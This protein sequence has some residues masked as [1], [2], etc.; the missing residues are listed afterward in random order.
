MLVV[1]ATCP[2]EMA[3]LR[4]AHPELSFL[5]P[6]IGAQG[7]DLEATLAGGLNADGAGLL[8][9]SSRAIMYAGGGRPEPIRAAALQLHEAINARRS[10]RR[11][12]AAVA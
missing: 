8:I 12:P 1:G 10:I 3:E 7:G 11:A 5:V 6:G 2:R 4:R 9:S